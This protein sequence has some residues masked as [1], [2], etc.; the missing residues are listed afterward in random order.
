MVYSMQSNC[1]V[2]VAGPLSRVVGAHVNVI[3]VSVVSQ[4]GRHSLTSETP[5]PQFVLIH[6][7]F[8]HNS[9]REMPKT[10]KKEE[11][12]KNEETPKRNQTPKKEETPKKKQTPK[13]E[14]TPKK[15]QTPKKETPKKKQTPKKEEAPKKEQTPKKGRTPNK[16]GTPKT[17][18]T[19]EKRPIETIELGSS[20]DEPEP[21]KAR[22]EKV[23]KIGNCTINEDQMQTL[24]NGTGQLAD[25]VLDAYCLAVANG[26]CYPS[27]HPSSFTARIF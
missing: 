11:A 9:P 12:P 18:R 3:H 5:D 23:I 10:P 1:A 7:R 4:I 26:V 16:N 27:F 2:C 25:C 19:P 24:F 21:K 8:T 20:P 6:L 22:Q 14:E 15:E 13:K 17:D